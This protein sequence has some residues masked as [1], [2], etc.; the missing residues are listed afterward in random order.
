MSKRENIVER[1]DD[2]VIHQLKDISCFSNRLSKTSNCTEKK[3][4]WEVGAGGSVAQLVNNILFFKQDKLK[5]NVKMSFWSL[6]L[7][8]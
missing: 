2:R 4:T 3:K 7:D 1:K 8:M 6:F 5:K